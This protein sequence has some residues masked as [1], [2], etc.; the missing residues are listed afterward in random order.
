LLV[1]AAWGLANG[2]CVVALA[3]RPDAYTGSLGVGQLV[4]AILEEGSPP[5]GEVHAMLRSSPG[6]RSFEIVSFPRAPRWRPAAGGT[7]VVF[8]VVGEGMYHTP[9][10]ASGVHEWLYFYESEL[11]KVELTEAEAIA[12]ARRCLAGGSGSAGGERGEPFAF[13]PGPAGGWSVRLAPTGAEESNP[14]VTVHLDPHGRCAGSA[15]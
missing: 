2:A 3:G 1:L 14:G 12:A 4:R 9:E 10:D 8:R 11:V 7:M 15:D 5:Y 6:E 13:G